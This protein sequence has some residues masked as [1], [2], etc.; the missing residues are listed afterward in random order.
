MG[1]LPETYHDPMCLRV[2]LDFKTM[3]L[4]LLF[5]TIFRN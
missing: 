3:G 5:K 1:S 4:V 2:R